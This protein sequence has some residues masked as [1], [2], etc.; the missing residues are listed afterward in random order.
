[1]QTARRRPALWSRLPPRPAPRRR[2]P[3]PAAFPAAVLYCTL[4]SFMLGYHVHEKAVL[5]VAVPLGL[6]AAA[7]RMPGGR[8]AAGDCLFLST[9]GTYSLFPLLFEPQEYAVKV[10]VWLMSAAAAP[11][12]K[13]TWAGAAGCL[14][15]VL[16]PGRPQP[17]HPLPPTRPPRAPGHPSAQVLLLVTFSLIAAEW[18]PRL[19]YGAS[20]AQPARKRGKGSGGGSTSG[21]GEAGAATED[22]RGG[23]LLSRAE[24]WYLWGL[25]GVELGTSW[26]LPAALG[27]R[28]PFLPLMAVSLYCSLGMLHAWRRLAAQCW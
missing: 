8:A 27:E 10:R 16:P 1:M 18:L 23:G 5:M 6:L 24:R 3:D 12:C 19:D 14:V 17:W 21:G 11:V 25:V 15:A 7:G 4:C 22:G 2:R 20:P 9:V 28:L 13:P 26:V